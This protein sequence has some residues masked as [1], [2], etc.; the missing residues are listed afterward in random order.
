MVLLLTNL[1]ASSTMSTKGSSGDFKTMSLSITRWGPEEDPSEATGMAISDF[2][3]Y[4]FKSNRMGP[5]EVLSETKGMVMSSDFSD[6]ESKL[7][8]MGPPGEVAPV[9]T[10]VVEAG[11]LTDSDFS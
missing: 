10:R 9:S 2:S 5:G 6:N 4:D 7:S 3:D 11:V 8:I 1:H